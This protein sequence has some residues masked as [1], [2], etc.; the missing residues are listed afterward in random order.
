M[1]IIKIKRSTIRKN[2]D[3]G[4]DGV[5]KYIPGPVEISI[6]HKGDIPKRILKH[7]LVVSQSFPITSD[8][9]RELMLLK[10]DKKIIEWFVNS[11]RSQVEVTANQIDV[12]CKDNG[13]EYYYEYKNQ[14]VTCNN[15]GSKVRF[16]E[17]KNGYVIDEY[18]EE[19]NADKC[20]ICNEFDSFDYKLESIGEALNKKP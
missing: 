15:C 14:F 13:P 20:P 10:N 11:G 1:E 18:G 17:I 2:P 4:M 7:C 12:T 3:Y 19:H 9:E 8:A 16:N 5:A 6:K